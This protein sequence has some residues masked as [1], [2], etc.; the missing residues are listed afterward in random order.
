MLMLERTKGVGDLQSFQDSK[1]LSGP[2]ESS[3][4]RCIGTSIMP[5]DAKTTSLSLVPSRTS[6]P[7][8]AAASLSV[9]VSNGT[10]ATFND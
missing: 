9:V 8:I 3:S 4:S 1:I 2:T 5:F 7:I 6:I 10:A